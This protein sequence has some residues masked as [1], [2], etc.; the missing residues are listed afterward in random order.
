MLD[1]M[2]TQKRMILATVFSLLFFVFYAMLFPPQPVAQNEQAQQAQSQAPQLKQT[3]SAATQTD[4]APA[5]SDVKSV[6]VTLK[7]D[8]F[9]LK[10]D[11]LGRIASKVMLETKYDQDEKHIEVVNKTK[12]PL[13]LEVRFSKKELN[14][15]ALNTAYTASI[16]EATVTEGKPVEVVLTQKLASTTV[17]KTLTFY[18]DGHYDIKV[19][20]SNDESYFLAAGIRPNVDAD[21]FT[22]HG[23]LI[24][25]NKDILEIIEDGEYV[26]QK[27]YH[28]ARLASAFDRYY[29]SMVYSKN[30]DM[31][32]VVS[33]SADGQD[34]P[35]LFIQGK[36]NLVLN[37]YLGAK[38][39]KTL[40]T[41]D[42]ILVDALEYGW[43]TFIAAP[44]FWLLQ[45]FHGMVGN[46]GVAII[47]V[48]ILSRIV[49]YPLS[50][51]GMVSMQKLKAIA[52]QVKEVQKK[53]KGDPQKMNAAT[54]ALYKKHG[55]NPL[56]GCLPLL[57]Q[58]PIF[59]SI[60]RVLLNSIELKGADFMLWITDLSQ[61]DPYFVLP[62]IMGATM[63]YQQ[64][65]TPTNFTDPMQ[66][67]IFKFLPLIFT[68][69]F[70]TFPAGLVLYWAVNNVLTIA[71]QML[72]NKKFAA[73]KKA[74]NGASEKKS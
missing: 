57:L 52:P 58:I 60:Y 17:T 23:V 34:D 29:A 32:V 14:K 68:L 43:F 64:K 74:K 36:Q 2:S 27:V 9:E 49:L 26:E 69:F 40:K 1:N 59:F 8:I 33:G 63:Y 37:G 47:L 65:I 4:A 41:I 16:S 61:M 21:G 12:R 35:I 70:F 72:V 44:M 71:Q 15:E 53:H 48:T 3:S 42:P 18:A 10:I 56:G 73:A 54:M 25:N 67:K 5:T 11:A 31:T 62:I 50:Y 7:N 28:N 51:K 55:A 6:L 39:Y 13:P 20:L 22:V 24:E 45:W 46:W 38:T 30:D 19:D 66:E